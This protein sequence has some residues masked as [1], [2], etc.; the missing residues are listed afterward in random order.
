MRAS[1]PVVAY[2]AA[3]RLWLISTL[4]IENEITRLTISRSSDGFT[5]SNP[6][7]AIEG[8]SSSGVV[9]DKNWIVCDNGAASPNR[10][11]CY[12]VYTDTVRDASLAAL[13]STDGGVTWSAP[14][15]IPVIDAVGAFPVIRP[16][17]DLVVDLQLGGRRIGS[18]S[19]ATEA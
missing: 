8:A 12:L 1:D 4:A 6:V 2:D 3:T 10:G 5:W 11:R 19:R 16:T 14:A 7:I 18:R 9:F 13:T 15:G 17:G